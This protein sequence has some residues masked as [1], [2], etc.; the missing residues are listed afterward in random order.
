M[1]T[2]PNLRFSFHRPAPAKAAEDD[3]IRIDSN[4]DGSYNCSFTYGHSPTKAPV[5]ATMRDGEVFRWVRNIIRLL[6]VDA[7]PFA[8]VQVDHY[9]MPSTLLD[10]KK[11]GDHYHRILDVV[12]F[13][14][15]V[16]ARKTMRTHTFFYDTTG[17][18]CM[19]NH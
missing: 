3:I 1:A 6:E 11:I 4:G 14:L 16:Q 2:T 13:F 10:V 17:D 5:S 8:F 12:E 15:D 7:D 19:E 18:C 9:L